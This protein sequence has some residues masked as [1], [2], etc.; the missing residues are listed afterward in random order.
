M[1]VSDGQIN[2]LRPFVP[3]P[4]L[5]L[6][7]FLPAMDGTGKLLRFQQSK[8]SQA[9]DLRC[10]SI[11]P[12]DLSSWEL[13]VEKTIKLIKIEKETKPLR[14]IYLCGESFGGC[15]ALKVAVTAS[16]LFDKLILIN[17]ASSFR[18]QPLVRWGSYLTQWLPSYLYPLSVTGLLPF[19]A[20]LG[21]MERDERQ[22]LLEA[23]QSV[24]QQTSIWRLELMRSFRVDKTDIE[25]LQ[26]P[27][28]AIASAA[29]RLLPSISQA[30]FLVKHL[31][32][33]KMVILPNSGHACL[34]EAD[35][36]LYQIIRDRWE[37]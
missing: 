37:T 30:R 11:P 32:E 15:L 20:A 18:Q 34:L 21:R 8:L 36:D 2:W 35:V 23:M 1:Q 22:A 6:F 31:P 26:L 7:V 17:S 3:K 29:D 27:V 4:E 13:L 9:F 28:L 33:A 12:N 16:E 24:S 14:P 25:A 5:P 19:L 10:L